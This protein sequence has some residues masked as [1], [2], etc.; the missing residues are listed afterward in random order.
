MKK[1]II[2]SLAV[3][4]C[5]S[6]LSGCNAKDSSTLAP[7]MPMKNWSYSKQKIMS[8]RAW[9]TL[10]NRLPRTMEIFPGC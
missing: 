3:V 5:V 4:L 6:L 8:N 10:T 7:R 9:P 2:T 1:S